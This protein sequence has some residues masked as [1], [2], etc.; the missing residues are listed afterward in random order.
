MT[1]YQTV[2]HTLL[3]MLYYTQELSCWW[4]QNY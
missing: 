1:A 3:L 4:G 2:Y